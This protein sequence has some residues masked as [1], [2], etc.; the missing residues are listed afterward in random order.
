MQPSL[1]KDPSDEELARDWMLS[2]RDL[3]EV[4]RCRGDDK[5]LSFAIQLCV[6]RAYGRFLG[7]DYAAVPV[8][9]LNHVGRQF[10]LPPVLF[11]SPPERKQN[12]G[13]ASAAGAASSAAL[14]DSAGSSAGALVVQPSSA[15]HS[16]PILNMWRMR[17]LGQSVA[18]LEE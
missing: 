3:V 16:A 2:E 14:D 7:D 15:T 17:S 11:A 10:G 9:I 5:R 12:W 18:G 13:H 4:R 1:P 6:L 8:R